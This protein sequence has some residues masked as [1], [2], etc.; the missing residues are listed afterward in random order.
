MVHGGLFSFLEKANYWHELYENPTSLFEHLMVKRRDHT[1]AYICRHFDTGTRV[2]D[3]GCGAGVLSEKL[4]ENHFQVTGADLSTDMLDLARQ[5]LAHLPAEAYRLV[6]ANC[7]NLPFEDAQF[8]LIVCLGMFGYFDNVSQALREIHRVLRPGGTL[9][10]S[11]RNAH[12]PYAFNLLELAKLP[13]RLLRRLGR[14]FTDG[15]GKQ[16]SP[17]PEA[18]NG[19]APQPDDGF[20]I[21]IYQ[22]PAQLI[23]GVTQRGYR[24]IHFDGLGYGP[25]AFAEY[26]L[27]PPQTSIAIS[28]FLDRLCHVTGLNKLSR[29]LA[30]VSFYVF[31]RQD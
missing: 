29:W 12:T 16:S 21:N 13:F 17:S 8:D 18:G 23:R 25:L 10:V 27:L 19:T 15:L 22:N 4:V 9:I 24:L 3:L 30:D 28:D 2:L 5:R 26:K 7:L 11:V 20:R 1:C 14:R 31:R 6:P